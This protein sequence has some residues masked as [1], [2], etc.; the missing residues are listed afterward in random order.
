M[1]YQT[2][3]L[4]VY[5]LEVYRNFFLCGMMTPDGVI[6]QYE[7]VE[8][9]RTAL[10]YVA[11]YGY[12]LCGFN[13]NRYDDP[14]MDA[15]LVEGIKKDAF[16]K[17]YAIIHGPAG[18]WHGA[19]K[20]SVDLMPLLPGRMSLKQVGIRLHHD[21]LQ[22]LPIHWNK[23]LT[24]DEKD[25][26]REYNKNDLRI[27]KKLLDKLQPELDLRGDLSRQYE[28]DMRS[29]GGQTIAQ[30]AISNEVCKLMALDIAT[31]K[32]IAKLNGNNPVTVSP[33]SWFLGIQP[34]LGT[35]LAY[36]LDTQASRFDVLIPLD[37]DGRVAL[38]KISNVYLD[39][40]WY[41]VGAG[42]L[43]SIDGAGSYVT[44]DDNFIVDIDATSY[45]PSI[46]L[47]NDVFPNHIG[48]QMKSVF[49]RIY[50]ERLQAKANGDKLT[51]EAKK[52]ILNSTFGKLADPYSP[53]YDPQ[54]MVKVTI[55]GQVALLILIAM[56]ADG[57]LKTV[58][59]NTD[60]I[61]VIGSNED[62]SK[63]GQIVGK[64]ERLTGFNMEYTWYKKISYMNVNNY[65][66]VTA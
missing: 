43:H 40:K 18:Q 3:K 23:E 41:K 28:G 2:T 65:L 54:A 60:G 9:L 62:K 25:I 64:W 6:S 46:M 26:I 49:Q 8:S 1:N 44:N 29:M 20:P 5:D 32:R 58:S 57:G 59:A 45:Y 30:A 14:V 15:F 31:L 48:P 52:L 38:P 12:E 50:D 55:L 36:I 11:K 42:G 4:I 19:K 47:N 10:S 39:D 33:P 21:K 61:T 17:S 34:T 35:N 27:T 16:D 56:L 51:A 7:D 22:E 13:S 37:R 66:G 53:L 24:E 63:L